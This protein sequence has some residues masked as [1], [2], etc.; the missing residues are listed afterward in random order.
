MSFRSFVPR[1]LAAG[2]A[3]AA[4]AA[5]LAPLARAQGT[6]TL[7]DTLSWDASVRR[8]IRESCARS[9][10]RPMK[11]DSLE[12]SRRSKSQELRFGGY[13]CGHWN[14][15]WAWIDFLS[16][17]QKINLLSKASFRCLSHWIL[18]GI[19]PAH[20][21]EGGSSQKCVVGQPIVGAAGF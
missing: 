13:V 10:P 7:A 3:L 19:L 6:P 20:E 1:L 4:L 12:E 9:I 2:L 8:G 16:T 5:P 18:S 11:V 15:Q 21:I 14:R 17:G